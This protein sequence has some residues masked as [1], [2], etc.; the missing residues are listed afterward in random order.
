VIAVA[1]AAVALALAAV[2]AVLF[3]INLRLYRPPPAPD[4]TCPLPAVAVL[5]PARNEERSIQAAVES[6]LASRGVQV[7]VLVLDDRS[8]DCTAKVVSDMEARDSRLRLLHGPPLPPGWCGKQHACAALAAEA[9]SPLLA[10]LDADVRLAPDGLARMVAFLN[11]SGADL[12]SGIPRQETGTL[13]ERL[14]IPLIHFVLLGFL[15]LW[16]L[17][18]RRHPAY[19]AG[20]GQLFLARR[21][22]YERAGGHAAIRTSRHDGITLPRAFR[23]AGLKTDL[24][25]ATAVAAC[26]MYRGAAELW[27]GLAKN[28]TEGLGHPRMIAPATLLL[29]GG[30]VLPLALLLSAPWL[31]PTATALAVAATVLLYSPR[32]AGM[33]RFRQSPLG[34]ALHPF[35]VT[36]LVAI[37]WYALLRGLLGWPAAWKGRLYPDES[38]ARGTRVA[39]ELH[40]TEKGGG[41]RPQAHG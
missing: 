15:P 16:R 6:A 38:R 9:R 40:S 24:C 19:A 36:A 17:R 5:I 32:L 39:G 8:E 41:R 30:G 4:T 31:P 2:P 7:E 10:F 14:V 11:A 23:R 33:R 34:A 29:L 37:Q 22:A 21:D 13:L 25:D 27:G 26:R 12:V 35:G 20:C 3:W 1:L 28:A 18:R